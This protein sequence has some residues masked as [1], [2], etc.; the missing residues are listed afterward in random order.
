MVPEAELE[1][2][3]G[4]LLPK[5]EGWFVL[6]ARDAGWR[7]GP[8][9]TA[10]CDFEGAQDFPQ[11]GVNVSVLQP[12]ETMA[13]YHWEVDQEDFLVLAG[14]ALLIVEG[15]ERPLRQWDFVHCPP[16]TKHTILGAGSGPCVVLAIGARLGSRGENWGGYTVDE[17]AGRHGVSVAED[18][19]VPREAYAHLP[20]RHP[21]AY[22]EGWLPG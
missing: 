9:R 20:Q 22:R 10:V 19:A 7:H 17:T 6:N 14:E 15:E 21:A 8:G 5:G 4:G 3:E 13:M 18:T 1:A 12:G 16:E 2:T 11:V